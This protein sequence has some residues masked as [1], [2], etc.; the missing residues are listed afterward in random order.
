MTYHDF[1]REIVRKSYYT[2]TKLTIDQVKTC[3]EI[4]KEVVGETLEEGDTVLLENFGRFYTTERSGRLFQN[5]NSGELDF[6]R[7]KTIP[8]V[9]FSKNFIDKLNKDIEEDEDIF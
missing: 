8:K 1:I 2:D 5:V 7:D 4:F 6:T 3:I 9:K